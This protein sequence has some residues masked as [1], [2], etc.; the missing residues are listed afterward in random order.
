MKIGPGVA[1]PN[2]SAFKGA[3]QSRHFLPNGGLPASVSSGQL[4]QG[5]TFADC[6]R[7]HG[8]PSC[9]DPDRDGVFTLPATIDPQA[10][11]LQHAQHACLSVGP[12]SLNI[13]QSPP[14]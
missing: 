7:A 4:A 11:E 8:V 14:A 12:S 1:D 6:V 10:P 9:P 3:N 5:V 13:N 2:S